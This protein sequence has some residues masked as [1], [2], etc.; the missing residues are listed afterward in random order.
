REDGGQ[1]PYVLRLKLLRAR[2]VEVDPGP[3]ERGDM[4]VVRSERLGSGDLVLAGPGS[5]REGAAISVK[6]GLDEKQLLELTIDAGIASAENRNVNESARFISRG[7]SDAWGFDFHLMTAMLARAYSEFDH[8]LVEVAPAS[9]IVIEGSGALIRAA[10]RVQATRRGRSNYLLG[11]PQGFTKLLLR[12]EK[13]DSGWK[14]VQIKGLEPL[15]FEEK[16]M[17]L[18]GAEVGLPLSGP[19]KR[20]KKQFCMPCRERMVDR[21]GDGP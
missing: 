5:I 18:L 12:M 1:K 4:V 8:P 19:E 11:S 13:L 2:R 15:G 21:F 17:K 14:I 9:D 6:G 20:E 3:V 7:Y 16:F 10:V